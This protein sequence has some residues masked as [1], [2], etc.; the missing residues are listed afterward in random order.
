MPLRHLSRRRKKG[1]KKA[2]L[3]P[4]GPPRSLFEGGRFEEGSGAGASFEPERTGSA[5]GAT[6][7]GGILHRLLAGP[8]LLGTSPQPAAPLDPESIAAAGQDPAAAA[9]AAMEEAQRLEAVQEG[10]VAE[11]IGPPEPPPENREERYLGSGVQGVFE[12]ATPLEPG[13][14]EDDLMRRLTDAVLN[15]RRDAP[16]HIPFSRGDMIALGILGGVSDDAF[17][18]IVLPL[19]QGDR[20]RTERDADRRVIQEQQE[21]RALQA[22]VQLRG[23]QEQR[24]ATRA[25][26]AQQLNLQQLSFLSL[27]D[28]REFNRLLGIENLRLKERALDVRE[29]GIRARMHRKVPAQISIKIGNWLEVVK[30]L[31][32]MQDNFFRSRG[33]SGGFTGTE[34]PGGPIESPFDFAT[35]QNQRDFRAALQGQESEIRNK[36]FGAAFTENEA[37]IAFA[38]IPDFGGLDSNVKAGIIQLRGHA[39]RKFRGYLSGLRA[40]GY[41]TTGLEALGRSRGMSDIDL[42]LLGPIG[43]TEIAPGTTPAAT[44]QIP[45]AP[46]GTEWVGFENDYQLVKE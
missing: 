17:K 22:L 28:Q 45:P 2:T 18:E 13:G 6:P 25:L 3:D 37:T 27:Q 30:A 4:S 11:P 34:V 7:P 29:M 21:L 41:D 9:Q 40:S 15:P 39:V 14:E 46:P 5:R 44:G 19:I 23:V 32:D 26:Q 16:V 31:D 42:G 36:I 1:R 35:T 10:T 12:D 8:G 38:F 43:F 33:G 20:L 24:R